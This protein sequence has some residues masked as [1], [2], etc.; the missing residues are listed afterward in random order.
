M[1]FIVQPWRKK[2]PVPKPLT[3]RLTTNSWN[4]YSF[5]TLHFLTVFDAEGKENDI[6]QVKIGRAGQLPDTVRTALPDE[7]EYLSEQFFSLGQSDAFY[8]NLR[9]LGN[10]LNE[11]ILGA[12]HDI[13]YSQ[14]SYERSIEEAVTQRSLL[15]D[16][17]I[18]TVQ[19]QFR[20]LARGGER[21]S[22]YQFAY[23]LPG[24]G[25]QRRD[26]QPPTI[27]TFEVLPE[28]NPPTNVHVIIGRNGVGKTHLLQGM[29]QALVKE[30][31]PKGQ[32]GTFL[33]QRKTAIRETL[34]ANV[35]SVTFSAFDPFDPLPE[36]QAE[37]PGLK[38]AYVGLK[39][40]AQSDGGRS[41]LK[42]HE[43]LQE[44][45]AGSLRA[46]RRKGRLDRL[47]RAVAAL[48]TDPVFRDN[49]IRELLAQTGSDAELSIATA[50]SEQRVS[51][52]AGKWFSRLSSGHK[53]VLLTIVRLVETVEERTLVLL[54]EP[55]AHLH[56]PLLAAFV[57]ALSDLLVN[58][59][60]VALIATH[61]PV[62]LQE[63]PKNCVWKLRR[64][65]STLLAE[66][67]EMETFGE[68][69]GILTREAFGLEVTEAGFHQLL[70]E[71][72]REQGS[73]AA[74]M[75]QFSGQLGMEAKAL[76]RALT[77]S[78]TNR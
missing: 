60:G 76:V 73:Y 38:Y 27:L 51:D 20:R 6:G 75:E 17:P 28:S 12:L 34:F 26:G 33:A 74:V 31:T 1:K 77:I 41:G 65:G 47:R 49:G 30:P 25:R 72:V 39:Q 43:D 35:V 13:A 24:I 78:Q 55:E 4:D 44:E 62:V 54:D 69:V 66:R 37:I 5:V 15:R 52:E 14:E 48:E 29:T 11:L 67:P 22:Q 56:P 58:R 16:I 7:F 32:G 64:H 18:L 40:I 3:A 10:E 50:A 9:K 36:G 53:I 70:R 68:N 57:R 61:S 2:M 42:S 59:N 23:Q 21:L 71:A 45:F 46:C 8:S 19:G 63:V